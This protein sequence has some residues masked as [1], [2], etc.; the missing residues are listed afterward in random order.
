M[1]SFHLDRRRDADLFLVDIDI[2][3]RLD[4]L[5]HIGIRHRTE[6]T[7]AFSALRGEPDYF[8]FENFLQFL[9]FFLLPL[10]VS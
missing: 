7:S 1:A 5:R 3:L 9:R 8:F 4:G 10:A 6:Q 2:H